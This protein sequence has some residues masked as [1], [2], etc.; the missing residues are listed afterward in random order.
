MRLAY[1]E[2][3]DRAVETAAALGL[4]VFRTQGTFYLLVN[5]A[6]SAL[7]PMDF[8]LRLLEQERVAVAPGEVFGPGGAGLVRISLAREPDEIAEGLTRIARAIERFGAGGG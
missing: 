4:D 2:R 5:V 7:S 6:A 8:T 1:R 3:R